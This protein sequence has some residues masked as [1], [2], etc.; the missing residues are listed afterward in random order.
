[1]AA[2]RGSVSIPVVG[3]ASSTYHLTYQLARRFGVISLN[4]KWNPAFYHAMREC[5]CMDRM[6]SMR[7]LAKPMAVTQSGIEIPYTQEEWEAQILAT[8]RTQVEQEDAQCIVVSC[9]PVFA[10]LLAE[11]AQQRLED[12]LG[13]MFPDPIA[14]AIATAEMQV[15]L[16]MTHSSLEYPRIEA[17][18][19]EDRYKDSLPDLRR[20]A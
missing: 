7:S 14:I 8:A 16:G 6:T 15:N 9:A 4:S 10:T 1:M 13:V 5:D 2:V 11:G 20:S 17:A 12:A 18:S 3:P 19:I